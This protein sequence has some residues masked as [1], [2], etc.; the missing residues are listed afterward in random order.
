[1]TFLIKE[2]LVYTYNFLL[3]YRRLNKKGY[4]YK[5]YSENWSYILKNLPKLGFS[6]MI[7]KI[8]LLFLSCQRTISE[9]KNTY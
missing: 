1:M 2:E 8:L 9:V 5:R 6:I 7:F 4:W 3:D